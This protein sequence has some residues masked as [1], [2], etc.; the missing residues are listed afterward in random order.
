M[1]RTR[2]ITPVQLDPVT[3][4]MRI[5]GSPYDVMQMDNT[6]P[7]SRRI[8]ADFYHKFTPL[9]RAYGAG[10]NALTY[11]GLVPG[12]RMLSVIGGGQVGAFLVGNDDQA[13]GVLTASD[14]SSAGQAANWLARYAYADFTDSEGKPLATFAVAF[15]G[16]TARGI[17]SDWRNQG[18]VGVSSRTGAVAYFSPV[19]GGIEVEAFFSKW[20]A[21]PEIV[22]G[23]RLHN[24]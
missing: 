11:V 24:R 10:N 13:I 8:Y 5:S 4:V 12:T 22:A 21:S 20:R 17:D 7:S 1:T 18:K 9:V 2:T 16:I 6:K 3:G 14:F 23:L 15:P 19:S